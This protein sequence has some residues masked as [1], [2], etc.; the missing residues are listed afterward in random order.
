M[1]I[2]YYSFLYSKTI[3]KFCENFE[4]I[5]SKLNYYYILLFNYPRQL[6]NFV[7]IY[8]YYIIT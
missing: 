3:A 8:K 6:N 5:I 2:H 4:K 1:V 7:L